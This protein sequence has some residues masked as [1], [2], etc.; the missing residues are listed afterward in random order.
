MVDVDNL[1][2]AELR[3]KL[4]EYGFPVMPITG[5]TR[6]VMVK[7]LKLL[8]ENKDKINSEGRRS[9]ARYSSD[10]DSES[11]TK[12]N[13]RDRN[14]RIT[15]PPTILTSSANRSNL[16]R[17]IR[18]NDSDVVESPRP[19]SKPDAKLSKINTI[20]SRKTTVTTSRDDFDTGSDTEP[21]VIDSEDNSYRHDTS[22][23]FETRSD[24]PLKSTVPPPYGFLNRSSLSPPKATTTEIPISRDVPSSF[25]SSKPSPS[26]YSSYT[27]ASSYSDDALERLNQIR[28]R[29]S[30]GSSAYDKPTA[31]YTSSIDNN[32]DEPAETPFLSNFTKRLSQ[33]SANSPKMTDYGFK[34]DIIKENDINGP[35]SYTRS[36]LARSGR[37]RDLGSRYQRQDSN[38]GNIVRNNMVSLAVVGVAFLFFVLI[39]V[40]YLGMRSDSSALDTAGYVIPYCVSNGQNS[41]KDENCILD[42][43]VMAAITLM[44]KIKPELERLALKNR[45]SDPS[46]KPYLSED[47]IINYVTDTQSTQGKRNISQEVNN[48]ELLIF[49]NPEWGI[50]IVEAAGVVTE[51]N[52][53]KSMKQVKIERALGNVGLAVLNP[54]LPWSCIISNKLFAIINTAVV[55][56]GGFLLIYGLNFLY[57]SYKQYQ[58]DQKDEVF[59]MVERIVEIL[60]NHVEEEKENNFLVINHVR[61]MIVPISD[62][63]LKQR[64]WEKAVKFINENESRIRT[65]I[66]VVQGE[67]YEVWRWLGNPNMSS[68]ESPRNKSWQGQAFETE[69]GSMNS[70]PCSPTPCLKIRG[71]LNTE[72]ILA[73]CAI[74]CKILHCAVDNNAKCIYLKC[75]SQN[76]A[77]VAYRNLHGWWYAGS[78][79]TV[80]YVRLERYMQRF[81]DSPVYGPPFL[82][83]PASTILT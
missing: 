68:T 17:S 75:A 15:A 2:D 49:K 71:I 63:K 50:S 69:V 48:L 78:L 64:T 23:S 57:K 52:V 82:R 65:E 58:Q 79:V 29:L 81:P 40:M 77:A 33:M 55:V 14:R 8:L 31:T 67:P 72:A 19:E 11:E 27:S 28:S 66:Q 9:L 6:K 1:S 24:S 26:R 35:G 42:N 18:L 32:V 53:L 46:V 44:K 34:S 13:R 74:Q 80:K 47:D 12:K 51:A 22:R 7:K 41:D 59:A 62:R 54:P 45:C 73:K 20:S 60:Q 4:M 83:A 16:R 70:L 3:T 21:E 39:G 56:G 61:D 76:D 5:T 38:M 10:D 25:V 43:E 36:Y 30:L 37:Y